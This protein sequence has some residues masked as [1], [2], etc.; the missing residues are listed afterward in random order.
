MPGSTHL[1][2][3]GALRC[4]LAWFEAA[5]RRLEVSQKLGSRQTQCAP[6][7]LGQPCYEKEYEYMS[8]R[9]WSFTPKAVKRAIKAAK[10]AAEEAGLFVARV[11]IHKTGAISVVV[12]KSA[13]AV[14]ANDDLDQE[15]AAFE[16]KH[17]QG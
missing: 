15:L 2:A 6:S 16:A 17:G 5:Q 14:G 9:P 1:K 8:S 3:P 7:A 12:G 4:E 11:D 13:E 10:E